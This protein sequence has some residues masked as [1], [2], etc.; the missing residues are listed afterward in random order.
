MS[1]K[2]DLL[3]HPIRMRIIQQLLLGKPLTTAQLLEELGDVPQAT[4]Y[5]HINLLIDAD[6]IEVVDTHKVKGTEERVFS[7]KKDHIQISEEETEV[8]SQ[9]DHL[10]HFSAYH[11]NLL[12][13]ATSYITQNPPNQYKENGFGYWFAPMHLTNDEFQ[14]LIDSIN[15][16]MEKAINNEPTPE[17]TARIFAGMFIPQKSK[18]KSEE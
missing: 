4:L 14:E 6:M 3:L 18:E 13:L 9:E 12:Q 17:R 10:R 7:V 2:A 15:K 11:A 8:T 16:Y 1:K 5:R